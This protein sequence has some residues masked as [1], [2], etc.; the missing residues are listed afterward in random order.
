MSGSNKGLKIVGGLIIAAVAVVAVLELTNTTHLFHDKHVPKTIPVTHDKAAG[1]NKSESSQSSSDQQ[2][3]DK[4][5]GASGAGETSSA[6]E[7][8]QPY[9]SLVSNHMP[10][11]NG[12][13]TDEQSACNTTPGATCYIKL[14]KGSTTT[15]LPAQK[16]GSDGSTLWSWNANILSSGDWTVSAV[17]S[18]NGQT[19]ST[20]DSI[21]LE[22]R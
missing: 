12:S 7:L 22:V 19:K 15:K 5:A 14:T 16:V 3:S 21:K 9:G 2:S 6:A 4:V 10:G 18:L 20:T 8:V 17:A 11:Q 13:G 1:Q